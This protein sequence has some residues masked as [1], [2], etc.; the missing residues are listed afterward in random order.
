M[1]KSKMKK[2]YSTSRFELLTNK[3]IYRLYE[4]ELRIYEKTNSIA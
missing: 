4:G 2:N 3:H 1:A